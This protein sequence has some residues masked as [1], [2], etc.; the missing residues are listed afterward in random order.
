M[1]DTVLAA[2]LDKDGAGT[3]QGDDIHFVEELELL[4]EEGVVFGSLDEGG[5]IGGGLNH[6]RDQVIEMAGD[7]AGFD[8]PIQR[9]QIH[10]RPSSPRNAVGAN[11]GAI[12]LR[13]AGE[14]IDDAL[15]LELLDSL[16][17]FAF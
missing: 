1:S 5:V 11:S 6:F 7:G 14:V 9:R 10:R 12:H 16:Q 8:S 2:L 15:D 3:D 17:A 13:T 4:W